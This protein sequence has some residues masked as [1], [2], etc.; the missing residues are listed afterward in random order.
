[1]IVGDKFSEKDHGGI[2]T[3]ILQLEKVYHL[4]TET[5]R[6]A[7]FNTEEIY[8]EILKVKLPHLANRWSWKWM[9]WSD[10]GAELEGG[11]LTFVQFTKFLKQNNHVAKRVAAILQV[12]GTTSAEG[13]VSRG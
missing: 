5:N 8:E 7:T 1:M 11:D 9:E 13:Q 2:Q 4:A 12:K 3:F 6:A 10:G